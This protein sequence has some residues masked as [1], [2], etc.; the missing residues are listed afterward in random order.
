MEKYNIWVFGVLSRAFAGPIPG[1]FSRRLGI[2]S[3][4]KVRQKLFET[5]KTNQPTYQ[6]TYQQL[7][8]P[9]NYYQRSFPNGQRVA[10]ANPPGNRKDRFASTLGKEKG[11]CCWRQVGFGPFFGGLEGEVNKKQRQPGPVIDDMYVYMYVYIIYIYILY[12]YL[13]L[14]VLNYIEIVIF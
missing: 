6:P 2:L 3:L 14:F 11:T 1:R 10:N 4:T 13:N 7:V 8:P 5:K 9:T 12:V